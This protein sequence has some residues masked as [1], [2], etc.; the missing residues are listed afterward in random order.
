M[1]VEEI[2]LVDWPFWNDDTLMELIESEF[3]L[4]KSRIGKRY[5]VRFQSIMIIDLIYPSPD[6]ACYLCRFDDGTEIIES[7]N[8]WQEAIQLD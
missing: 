6:E 2:L 3:N 4:L 8:E 7:V 5:L 1:T